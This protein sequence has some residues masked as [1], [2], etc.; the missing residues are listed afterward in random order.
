MTRYKPTIQTGDPARK[1]TKVG[2]Y[3]YAITVPKD[4]IKKLGW[5]ERQKVVVELSG[6]GLRIKDWEK[7]KNK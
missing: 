6:K 5:R 4:L 3:S 1:V 7:P 2:K